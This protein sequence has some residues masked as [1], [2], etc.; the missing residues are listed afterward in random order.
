[1]GAVD[2]VVQ[3]ESPPSVASGLQ[4]VGPRR[5]P[6][7]RGQP[8]GALPEVP[9]RPRA[10]RGRRRAD[11]GRP[12]RGAAPAEHPARRARPAGRGDV[13]PRRVD[14]RRRARPGPPLGLLLHAHPAG[15]RVGARHARRAA[16]PATS[17][18]SCAPASPGTACPTPSPAAAAGPTARRHLGRHH[19]RPRAVRRLPRHRRGPRAPGRR[20]RRG[21]GLRVAGRRPVHPR[22]QH[23]ADR[24]HHPR[25][26]ARH[27]GA[28][29][30]RAAAVLEGRLARPP[31]R[32]GPRRRRLRPRG[33]GAHAAMPRASG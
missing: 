6:G 12:D 15:A 10:D 1:M 3:V 25:P 21:D 23:L 14:R 19:P 18:P 26:G 11:A 20:A 32:A 28:R 24:G 4:R 31:R 5:P 16:T 2:L 13:R 9:R 17:S 33:R 22:H 27:P 7:R 29:A 30:A 8:R